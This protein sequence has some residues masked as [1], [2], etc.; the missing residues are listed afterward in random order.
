MK[1]KIKEIL[2]NCCITA[3]TAIKET[4]LSR[5]AFYLYKQKDYP[6]YE[7]FIKAHHNDFVFTSEGLKVACKKSGLT[8]L[9]IS[10]KLEI[11]NVTL[12]LF[13]HGKM[14]PSRASGDY[15]KL[16]DFML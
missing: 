7:A 15:Y 13:I 11:H 6:K 12:N 2:Y 3:S 1:N 5:N 9:Q 14:R 8:Q 4:G 16:R 10:D